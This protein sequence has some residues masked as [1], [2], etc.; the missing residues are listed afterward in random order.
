MPIQKP[1]RPALVSR[2]GRSEQTAGVGAGLLDALVTVLDEVRSGRART[3]P[4]LIARTGL[5]RAV[6][7]QRVAELVGRGLLE[8]AELGASTGGRAPR[9]LHLRAEVGH[10]LVADLGATSAA[11]AVADLSGRLIDLHEEPSDIAAGPAVVLGRVEQ[12]FDELLARNPLLGSRLWGIGIGVP[13]PVEFG[14]GR[15]I[16]P[17]IMPGWDGFRIRELFA[18]RYDVPVWVDNDVN[19][20]ALGE[21]RTGIAR[22][23]GVVVVVKLG[24]GIGAGVVIGGQLV[25]GAQGCAGDVGHIQVTDDPSVICR[26]GKIGCLEAL[27]GGGAVGRLAEQPAGD[28]RSRFLREILEANGRITATD[29][30][31]AATHGDAPA[32]ELINQA[33]RLV[34]GMLATVV[35]LLNPSLIVIGGGFARSGDVL[36]AAIRQTIYARSLPLATRELLVQRSALDQTGG[37]I[38]AAAMV[39]D[40]LFAPRTLAA[41]LEHGHPGGQPQLAEPAR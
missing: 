11:V 26:C 32:L 4:E 13:G 10:V 12:L 8:E 35:N 22:D 9:I 2:A 41:W 16:S 38:G 14:S 28:G 1:E 15:P 31:W 18:E 29:V 21:V 20:M 33:G 19:V 37:L 3:R 7:T 25:R 17:P 27:A 30:A 40:E 5:G 34:G 36:L 24:T 23:H 39:A 6:V